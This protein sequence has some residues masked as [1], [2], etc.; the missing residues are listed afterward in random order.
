MAGAS[1]PL[2]CGHCKRWT[3]IYVGIKGPAQK[4]SFKCGHCG[5][6]TEKGR[7]VS[8]VPENG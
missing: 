6:T 5:E 8:T 2:R 3:L 7:Y 4:H 1:K